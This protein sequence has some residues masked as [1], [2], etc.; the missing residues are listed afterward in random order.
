MQA[1][2]IPAL[3]CATLGL[4]NARKTVRKNNSSNIFPMPKV[5]C[6]TQTNSKHLVFVH[7]MFGKNTQVCSMF[8]LGSQI[9]EPGVFPRKN[10]GSKSN[11]VQT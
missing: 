9:Y 8:V 10:P 3:A 5:V 11:L 2:R 1:G 6:I 4:G 7:S